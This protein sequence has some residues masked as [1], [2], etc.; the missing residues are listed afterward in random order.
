MEQITK[1]RINL[2]SKEIEWQGSEDFI[3]KY[4][5]V[6]KE[7]IEKLKDN[8]TSGDWD[9]PINTE[10]ARPNLNTDITNTELSLPKTFGEF[11]SKF[12]RNI[13]VVDKLLI[14]AYFVQ[15]NSEDGLFTPKE[16]AD[17]LTEQ[18]VA[19]TNANAFINSLQKT[20]KL[21]RHAGKYKVHEN[22]IEQLKQLFSK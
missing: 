16:A 18:S 22:A 17:L 21:F 2:K 14:A 15:S 3:E 13:K 7:F 9:Q 6:I 1:I 4:D 20:G 5:S 12:P 11:Y 19:V 8:G 10:E